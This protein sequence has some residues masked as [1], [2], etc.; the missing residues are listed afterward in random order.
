M[1][2]INSDLINK[3]RQK[4]AAENSFYVQIKLEI[5]KVFFIFVASF[6]FFTY[7]WV[8]AWFEI[9]Y[10]SKILFIIYP[11]FLLS[12]FTVIYDLCSYG[13]TLYSEKSSMKYLVLAIL[14][15]TYWY[16][17]LRYLWFKL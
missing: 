6:Y 10:T 1:V 17:I 13:I 11:I 12:T 7:L 4:I 15:I 8:L 3:I 2:K 5:S 16:L 9:S 14:T